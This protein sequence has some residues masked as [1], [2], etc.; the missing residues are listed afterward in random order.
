MQ[1]TGCKPSCSALSVFQ[2]PLRFAHSSIALPFLAIPFLLLSCRYCDLSRD[3]LE[4]AVLVHLMLPSNER[5][6]WFKPP[7]HTSR[8]VFFVHSVYHVHSSPYV[9]SSRCASSA[10]LILPKASIKFFPRHFAF[11]SL[12][13]NLDEGDVYSEVAFEGWVSLATRSQ[14]LAVGLLRCCD[15]AKLRCC[16]GL[17]AEFLSVFINKD[18]LCSDVAELRGG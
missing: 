3:E 17:V 16:C 1:R 9:T 15:V 6:W 13:W 14:H 12:S 10:S 2:L 18:G 8:C 5:D 4:L 11:Y 7:V